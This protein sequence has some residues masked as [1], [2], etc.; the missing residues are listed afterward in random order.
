MNTSGA[1]GRIR[2]DVGKADGLQ[3][4]SNRPLWDTSIFVSTFY[5][6]MLI[7]FCKRLQEYLT[8]HYRENVFSIYVV[9]LYPRCMPPTCYITM[10]A[11][12][13]KKKYKIP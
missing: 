1:G 2:T 5:I 13:I 11:T 12:K 4:R 7:Y 9:E 6:T 8:S 3:D 10:N